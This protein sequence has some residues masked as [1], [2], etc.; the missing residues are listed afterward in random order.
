M[1]A[2]WLLSAISNLDFPDERMHLGL[3]DGFDCLNA[4][5]PIIAAK[6]I[7]PLNF[8]ERLLDSMVPTG[9]MGSHLL[10]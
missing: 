4:L 5:A 1:L 10:I 8:G 2:G 6:R 9:S 7:P 3:K